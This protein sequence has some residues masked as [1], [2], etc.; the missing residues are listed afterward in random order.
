MSELCHHRT[1]EDLLLVV[2][3]LLRLLEVLVRCRLELDLCCR[4]LSNIRLTLCKGLFHLQEHFV[5]HPFLFLRDSG[6]VK[7]L[8]KFLIILEFCLIHQSDTCHW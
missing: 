7:L 2:D 8:Q 5:P 1:G 6:Q 4:A 3:I